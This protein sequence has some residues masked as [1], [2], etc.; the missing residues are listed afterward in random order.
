MRYA[1]EAKNKKIVRFL[2]TYL[3][4]EFNSEDENS[5]EGDDYLDSDESSEMSSS[6]EDETESEEDEEPPVLVEAPNGR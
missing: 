2:K 6:D 3:E 4:I 5:D 1:Q